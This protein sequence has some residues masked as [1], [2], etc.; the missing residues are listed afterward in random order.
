M[1]RED[2]GPAFPISDASDDLHYPN[3]QPVTSGADAINTRGMSLRDYFAGQAI[4]QLWNGYDLKSEDSQLATAA[5]KAY[6][7]AD[8]MLKERAK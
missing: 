6:A 2:G 5:A 1:S 7:L 8:A 4:S 3:G